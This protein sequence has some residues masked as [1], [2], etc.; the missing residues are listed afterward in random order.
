MSRRSWKTWAAGAL[1]ALLAGCASGGS[2]TV[3]AAIIN[4][5]VAVAASGVS[6]SQ[7]GCFSACAPGT[8]CD[9]NTGYCVA[10]PCRGRCKDHEQCVEDGFKSQCVALS[11]PGQ[12]TV[13][14]TKEAKTDP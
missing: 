7:G 12:V 1:L 5:T 11:L 2:N 6:R 14:P 3:A 10:L 13:E 9:P 4:T 8:T